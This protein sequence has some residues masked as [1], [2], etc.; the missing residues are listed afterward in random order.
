[1]KL[2]RLFS[3]IFNQPKRRGEFVPEEPSR[4]IDLY[5]RGEVVDRALVDAS[6]YDEIMAFP[7]VGKC[8]WRA[9]LANWYQ[10]QKGA[11]PTYY[12]NCYVL[13]D[14]VKRNIGMHRLVASIKFSHYTLENSGYRKPVNHIGHNTV[15][16]RSCKIEPCMAR[17]NSVHRKG[18]ADGAYL[19]T[20]P[21]VTIQTRRRKDGTVNRTYVVS[22]HAPF[23][24]KGVRSTRASSQRTVHMGYFADEDEAGERSRATREYIDHNLECTRD[25]LIDLRHRLDKACGRKINVK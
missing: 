11:P 24:S 16:N 3:F 5:L 19:S 20:Y 14:G 1:M 15:D 6:M 17:D 21:H 12:A 22:I 2:R 23:I 13:I 4:Y 18:K 8:Q 7:N 9:V 10:V 25:D